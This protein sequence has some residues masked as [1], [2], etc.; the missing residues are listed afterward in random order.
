MDMGSKIFSSILCK[1]L[2]KIIK[3]HGVKY[4]FG[5]T[6]GVG[7]QDGRFTIKTLLHLRHAH[8]LPTLVL[9]ADIVKAFDTS[10]HVLVIKILEK[11][12]CPPNLRSMIERMYKNRIIRLIIGKADTTIPFEVS[13]KQGY[14]MV[15]VLFLFLIMGFA[16]TLEKEWV[17][18]G[19]HK[20]QFRRHD[21]SPQS[22][23]RLTSHPKQYFS[24]GTLSSFFC[25]LYVDDGAFA[26]QSWK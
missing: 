7:C 23:G 2:F 4:Q 11:Y 25:V 13:V 8:N 14:S 21:N 26:F 1:R 20:L 5:S 12:V 22:E 3:L 10:N 9:F 15:P 6:P 17:K 19:L 18:I 16:E 24:E